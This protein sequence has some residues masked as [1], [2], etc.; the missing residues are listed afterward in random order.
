MTNPYSTLEF[1]IHPGTSLGLFEIGSSLWTILETLRRLQH[2]YPQVDIKFDPDSSTTTPILIHLRPHISLLFSGL[3]QRLHTISIHSLQTSNPPIILKYKDTVLSSS[4]DEIVLRRVSVNRTFGPTYPSGSGSDDLKYPGI[5]FSFEEDSG[6]GGVT[7]TT[8]KVAENHRKG[9]EIED[10]SNEVKKIM[11]LQKCNDGKIQDPLD[12][13]TECNVMHG[14]IERAIIKVHDGIRLYFSPLSTTNKPLHIRL[15]QT[16][17]QDLTLDLGPPL[18]IHY[19]EDE[20]MTIHSTENAE[21]DTND[22]SDYFYNYF[23]HGLDFFISGSTHTVKKIIIHSNIPGSP[24][25]QRYKRCNWEIEGEPEDDEDDTPPRKRFYDR[26]ETI[27]HFLSPKETPPS[28][29]L[30]RTDDEDG[31]QLPNA[32]TRLYGYDGIILE[33]LESSQVVS[34]T[35]F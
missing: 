1:D 31:L 6:G 18:R 34:V 19:K 8:T 9:K 7:T 11:I 2:Q 28:M 26:F 15:H 24:L 30:N 17:A 3:H 12:G 16:T 13:V 22:E 35:L 33:V 21:D 29:V 27:S 20:R 5:W 32:T 4:K 23:Q 25:F 14:D 10:R